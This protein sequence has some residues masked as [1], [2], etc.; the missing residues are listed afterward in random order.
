MRTG[1]MV[2][3]LTAALMSGLVALPSF[4]VAAAE[5]QSVA[6]A[7]DAVGLGLAVEGGTRALEG[8]SAVIEV[9]DDSDEAGDELDERMDAEA[10]ETIE[11]ITPTTDQTGSAEG[12]GPPRRSKPLPLRSR[13]LRMPPRI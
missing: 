3:A 11:T 6:Q 5:E 1:S 8:A 7:V 2:T 13:G 12:G 9:A 4:D 10:A